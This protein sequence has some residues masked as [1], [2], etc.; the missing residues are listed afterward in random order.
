META[1]SWLIKNGYE[2][3]ANLIDE[4]MKKW[5]SQGKKTRRNWWEKLCGDRKGNP[6]KVGKREIPILRAAQ[7][8]QG[9]PVSKNALC[10]NENERPPEIISNTRWNKMCP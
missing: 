1:H 10:R 9:F 7:I 6:T 5:K 2:D 4:I 8:R 3:I